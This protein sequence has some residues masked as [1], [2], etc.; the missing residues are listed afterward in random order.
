MYAGVDP[1]AASLHVGN[2]LPLLGLLHF[3]LHGHTALALVSSFARWG[4]SITK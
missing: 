2:L 3:A 4:D 1:S